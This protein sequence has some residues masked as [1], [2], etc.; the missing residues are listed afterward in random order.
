MMTQTAGVQIN[1]DYGS[2]EDAALKM[3]TAMAVTSLVTAAFANSPIDS[4][5]LNGWASYRAHIWTHTDPERC[6]LIR[7]AVEG[8]GMGLEA[9]LQYALDVPVMFLV[10]AGNYIPVEG[11]TFRRFLEEGYE[12]FEPVLPD[13]ELHLT[14][15]FPEARFKTYLEV[16]GMDGV[17]RDLGLA[18]AALWKGILYSRPACDEAWR[19]M[20]DLSWEERLEL[21]DLAARRGTEGVLRGRALG[22]W[23]LDLVEIARGG[24]L[25]PDRGAPDL[26]EERFL[27]PLERQLREGGGSPAFHLVRH[28]EGDWG[29]D[30]GSLVQHTAHALCPGCPYRAR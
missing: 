30:F 3:R 9:W 11:L 29:G 10:R 22:D 20:A 21:H 7:Q 23:A 18:G 4:G 12:E 6:G 8:E 2:E 19:L 15:I 1:L 26:G 14:T 28:W 13:W 27:E 17:P 16:R 25:D 5:G 24:L